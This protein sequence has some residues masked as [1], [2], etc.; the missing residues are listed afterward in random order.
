[1]NRMQKELIMPF[2]EFCKLCDAITDKCEVY[3]VNDA[4]QV[5]RVALCSMIAQA[6]FDPDKMAREEGKLLK[7]DVASRKP[8]EKTVEPSNR[9]MSE[10]EKTKL[11]HD[12]V[13]LCSDCQP[14]ECIT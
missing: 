13:D 5:T 10:V 11:W 3:C 12:I 1:M 14:I 4:I 6:A 7:Q 2:D 8:F 9:T